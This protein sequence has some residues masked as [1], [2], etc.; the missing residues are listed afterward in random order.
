MP[1]GDIQRSFIRS[2]TGFKTSSFSVLSLHPAL[3]KFNSQLTLIH[4]SH[5]QI[6]MPSKIHAHVLESL[7]DF[8]M[9]SVDFFII[10]STF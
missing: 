1:D 8:S 6:M 3:L 5:M 10:K 7:V 4:S 9:N 2:E